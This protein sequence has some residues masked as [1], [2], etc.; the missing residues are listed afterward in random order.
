[1]RT[2]DRRSLLAGG[3]ALAL[4]VEVPAPD[5]VTIWK[6]RTLGPTVGA[7]PNGGI[8]FREDGALKFRTADGTLLVSRDGGVTWTAEVKVRDVRIEFG[9]TDPTREKTT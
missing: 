9:F 8:L 4:P 6:S 5:T 3:A 1:M 7:P 2:L